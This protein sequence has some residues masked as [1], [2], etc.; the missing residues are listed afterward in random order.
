MHKIVFLIADPQLPKQIQLT[1][2]FPLF[3]SPW[4]KMRKPNS[5]NELLS[6]IKRSGL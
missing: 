2:K 1:T 4:E 6:D 3:V 5:E